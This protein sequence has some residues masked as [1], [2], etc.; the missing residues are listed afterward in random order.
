MERCTR[1]ILVAEPVESFSGWIHLWGANGEIGLPFWNSSQD[2][3]MSTA[4][5]AT[6]NFV[7]FYTE[8]M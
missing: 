5:Q 6:F 4:D 2:L 1:D 7:Q 8:E 3:R